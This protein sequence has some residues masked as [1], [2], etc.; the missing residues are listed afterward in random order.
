MQ[1]FCASSRYFKSLISYEVDSQH[2]YTQRDDAAQLFIGKRNWLIE[3]FYRHLRCKHGVLLDPHGQ[4]ESG[5]WNY[6]ADKRKP[7]RGPPLQ[8]AEAP[9]PRPAHDHSA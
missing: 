7:W 1:A 2:F 4:P 8:P 9:D 6:E 3:T 5:Q